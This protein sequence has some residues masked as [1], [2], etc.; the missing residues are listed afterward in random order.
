MKEARA[1]RRDQLLTSLLTS[2]LH[3]DL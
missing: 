3:G 2:L 1:E